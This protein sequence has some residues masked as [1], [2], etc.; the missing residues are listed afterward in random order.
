MFEG[1]CL[2][3][4]V[5][6]RAAELIG[7]YVFCHCRSCRKANGS[8]FAA[9]IASPVETFELLAG[10]DV[11]QRYESSPQKYRY[12]C[13]R[14][15]SPVYTTVGRD[16]GVVRVRLGTLDTPFEEQPAA[17]IFVGEAAAWHTIVDG[18]PRFDAWPSGDLS[19]PGS[20]Q[21]PSD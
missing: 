12:F 17:H 2:C 8:A 1:S 18:A 20:K 7:P 3:R 5:Q 6:Y 19:I 10:A 9:N 21:P 13:G 16:P 4:A 11:L 15:G 14:C